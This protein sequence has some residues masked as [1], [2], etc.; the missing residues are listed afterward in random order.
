MSPPLPA[1]A[2][3]EGAAPAAEVTDK[4]KKEA[5]EVM[6]ALRSNP[7][8]VAAVVEF[9]VEEADKD[10][11][12]FQEAFHSAL[13]KAADALYKSLTEGTEDEKVKKVNDVFQAAK[14]P[15]SFKLE[16][17]KLVVVA[18]EVPEETAK[19][20]EKGRELTGDEKQMIEE[21][22][23]TEPKL[24]AAAER[25]MAG[26]AEDS[27][28]LEVAQ[29]FFE[30]FN[31][32]T[33]AEK[34]AI[35]TQAPAFQ[36]FLK[37]LPADQQKFVNQL[38]QTMVEVSNE[39][40]DDER[41]EKLDG[42]RKWLLDK[43]FDA[44]KASEIDKNLVLAQLQMR[45]IDT[46]NGEEILKDPSKM[47]VFEGT[48][49]ERGFNQIMGLLGYILLS[50]QKLKDAMHP[51]EKKGPDA[52][53]GGK[54]GPEA[55]SGAPGEPELK[56]QVKEKDML[57]VRLERQNEIDQNKKLLDGDPA[58]ADGSD[59]KIGLRGR[60]VAL[61]TKDAQLKAKSEQLDAQLKTINKASEPADYAAKEREIADIKTEREKIA[62]DL[63]GIQ[64]Q[65][66]KVEARITQLTT[67]T[68]SLEDIQ[69]RT[70]ALRQKIRDTQTEMKGALGAPP[71][72]DRAEAKAILAALQGIRL[73]SP[74][75]A[76]EHFTV[77][78]WGD[79]DANVDMAKFNAGADAVKKLGGNS[80]AWDMEAGK[81]LK[82][83]EAFDVSLRKAL[84]TLKTKPAAAPAPAPAA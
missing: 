64:E 48:N 78:L 47:K 38:R 60:E 79:P 13:E 36:K 3:G 70:E 32:K 20:K 84:D 33:P 17:G 16:G 39:L 77:E 35:L 1:A 18:A 59:T 37:E 15:V 10:A 26:M 2:P 49:V 21:A 28:E 61:T 22:F 23:S 50:I 6:E 44:S 11:K 8:A 46:S 56:K 66:T 62:V 81:T 9:K 57:R 72:A 83:P 67:E 54:P 24:K 76:D 34:K 73:I 65:K 30:N 31:A 74:A 41:A 29:G 80:V 68:K 52:P 71:I 43:K 40:T 14:S 27:P 4:Q 7:E 5:N 55:A 45:G 51:G 25:L 75:Q 12:K 42:A 58:A 69:K 19:G 63:K 82:D 53:A